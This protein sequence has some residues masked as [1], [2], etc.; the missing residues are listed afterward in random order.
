MCIRFDRQLK[1]SRQTGEH[2][3]L[4]TVNKKHSLI[5]VHSVSCPSLSHKLHKW[6]LC[7]CGTKRL[8]R[9]K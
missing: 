9:K 6:N 4:K 2:A 7:K 8:G 1:I 3:I 5:D